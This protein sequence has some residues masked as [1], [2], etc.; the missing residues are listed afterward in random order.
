MK[1]N[2]VWVLIRMDSGEFKMQ[3]LNTIRSLSEKF[4]TYMYVT[5]GSFSSCMY[6]WGQKIVDR[7]QYNVEV[8]SVG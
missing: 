4:Y 5:H 1:D 8:E 6:V 2:D 7:D 3:R